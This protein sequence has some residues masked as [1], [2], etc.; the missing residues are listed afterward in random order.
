MNYPFENLG[1]E[2]FQQLCQALLAKAN[3]GV[4]C[5]PVGQPDG[6]RDATRRGLSSLKKENFLVY[7]VKFVRDPATKKNPREWLLK[8]IEDEIDKVRALVDRSATGYFLIT[9]VRGSSHLDDGSIDQMQDLLSE[10]LDLPAICWWRDDIERR[11]DDA[12]DIKWAYPEVMTGP[13]FLRAIYEAGLA[14]DLSR[15]EGTLRA[16]LR[17]QYTRDCQ[18][19]FRQVDLQNG[20]L[21]LFVD[22]PIA[23]GERPFRHVDHSAYSMVVEEVRLEAERMRPPASNDAYRTTA[24]HRREEVG[25]ASFLLSHASSANFN[26]V[27]LEGGP[28]QGKST[29]SQYIAQVHRIRLLDQAADR[30]RLPGQHVVAPVRFPIRIDLRDFAQWLQR[31]NPFSANSS[32]TVSHSMPLQLEPFIAALISHHAGGANFSVDDLIAVVKI[33]AISLVLDG[34][35][36][37]ADLETRKLAVDEIG[38]GCQRLLENAAS[39]QVIVTSRPAIF[40]DSPRLSNSRF[41]YVRLG[42]LTPALI[43]TYVELWGRAR[44]VS[45]EIHEELRAFVKV[46]L[47]EPHIRELARNPMQLAILLSL[48]SARGAALPDKRTALYD[49]YIEHFLA[50]E[51]EKNATIRDNRELILDLHKYLAWVMHSEAEEK[52]TR[53]S[54]PQ[55]QLISLLRTYLESQ[56]ED[57][58]LAALLFKDMVDRVFVLVSRHV[59]SFEFEVQPL[60]E[61]FTARFLF[62]TAPLSTTGNE[63]PGAVPDRF[64]GIAPRANWANV[65]RFFAGCYSKGEIPSLVSSLQTLYEDRDLGRTNLLGSLILA[66]MSDWVFSQVPK[67][68]AAVAGQLTE[69]ARLLRLAIESSMLTR[70]HGESTIGVTD[71]K[72]AYRIGSRCLELLDSDMAEASKWILA[73]VAEDCIGNA[74]Q[75]VEEW[76]RRAATTTGEAFT[77][78][79]RIGRMV[80]ALRALEF[81]KL[82]EL[83]IC[84]KS[85]HISNLWEAGRDDILESKSALFG[86]A[87]RMVLRSELDWSTQGS[88]QLRLL[89]FGLAG[90]SYHFAM[91]QAAP[92]A[93]IEVV[94]RYSGEVADRLRNWTAED[95]SDSAI[96]RFLAVLT[97]QLARPVKDWSS[98]L[99]PWVELTDVATQNWGEQR[100]V[101]LLAAISAGAR[102]GRRA[103]S[104]NSD[105]FSIGQPL[106]ERTRYARLSARNADYWSTQ[107]ANARSS[108]DGLFAAIVCVAWCPFEVL[109]SLTD[110]L[111]L[112]LELLSSEDWVWLIEA[113]RFLRWSCL[114]SDQASKLKR[115]SL[116]NGATTRGACILAE[117]TTGN[118][119]SEIVNRYL[120]NE[121]DFVADRYRLWVAADFPRFGKK[122]WSPDLTRIVDL[123]KGD[124][125]LLDGHAVTHSREG[126]IGRMSVATARRLLDAPSSYP[127]E[128][129]F[130]AE[131]SLRRHLIAKTSSLAAVARKGCWFNDYLPTNN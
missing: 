103:S 130:V 109:L 122:N 26:W 113:T 43:G 35:D 128:L 107:F 38:A 65:A 41:A 22:V 69:P 80:G 18:V 112:A 101:R 36:E 48:V 13:D 108:D 78:Q 52:G 127:P 99:S 61:Y 114:S 17:D 95:S 64:E 79:L 30:K 121:S 120:L 67:Q 39:L 82:N 9:N 21:D 51:S 50:R 68:L 62:D 90:G 10:K 126:R 125:S 92:L 84:A 42:S 59:G 60:R 104:R 74:P 15:R 5:F 81:N 27:V 44:N 129:V 97:R 94:R 55:Q 118:L 76:F 20:L 123:Y 89:S 70:R 3:P 8:I 33:S 2:R 110:K 40:S 23:P 100:A 58:S 46:K 77:R 54:I 124:L 73:E 102:T 119:R 91:R 28:G 32:S 131:K 14:Q 88:S 4:Q 37:I 25:A 6:G 31:R 117:L 34:L 93:M 49:S 116:P 98:S 53:G 66:L 29:I 72:A 75:I 19:K 45:A 105:L 47:N 7:Q 71:E 96:N 11:L 85:S 106:C 87:L 16:F 57:P 24:T 111:G 1:D 83:P 56:G 63:R 115:G 12:W 86:E